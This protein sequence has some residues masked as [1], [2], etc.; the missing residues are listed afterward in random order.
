MHIHNI[1]TIKQIIKVKSFNICVILLSFWCK[2]LT[3]N[4]F[5]QNLLS[6]HNITLHNLVNVFKNIFLALV[7]YVLQP[8]VTGQKETGDL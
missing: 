4:S 8:I 2:R 3:E 5:M 6:L 7:V 1:D